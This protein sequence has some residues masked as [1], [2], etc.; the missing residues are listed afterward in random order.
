M[1]VVECRKRPPGSAGDYSGGFSRAIGIIFAP[2][3][4]TRSPP[5]S[6]IRMPCDRA[7]CARSSPARPVGRRIRGS[8]QGSS[9]RNPD[10]SQQ[11][12]QAAQAAKRGPHRL[13]AVDAVPRRSQG[14][15]DHGR[16]SASSRATATSARSSRT[17]GRTSRR[18]TAACARSGCAPITPEEIRAQIK[19]AEID[20]YFKNDPDARAVGGEA[21]GRELHPARPHHRRRRCTNPIIRVNQVTS[22]WA[23]R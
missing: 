16:S 12:E 18:S 23:S 2:V 7:R 17:T 4:C 21:A 1:G 8:A 15:E 3:A 11:A 13:R 9:S 20:A 6:A 19:Q 14:Q 10:P 5:L 22:A